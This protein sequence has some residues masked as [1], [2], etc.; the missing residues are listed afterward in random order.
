MH[1]YYIIRYVFRLYK[2]CIIVFMYFY[3]YLI[4]TKKIMIDVINITFK[5]L[6]DLLKRNI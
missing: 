4:C 1:C 5:A 6:L 3:L 2:Y